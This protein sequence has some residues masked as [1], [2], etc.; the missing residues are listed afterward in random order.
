MAQHVW[1][2]CPVAS[3]AKL[4]RLGTFGAGGFDLSMGSLV[5][6]GTLLWCELILCWT[7]WDHLC[8]PPDFF[9]QSWSKSYWRIVFF[10][11]CPVALSSLPPFSLPCCLDAWWAAISYQLQ[12][13]I[14]RIWM[15]MYSC[16][17]NDCLNLVMWARNFHRR[18]S[19][20]PRLITR[21]YSKTY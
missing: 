3:A 13:H 1:Q 21:Q 14:H 18:F 5:T 2:I 8:S 6:G 11:Q 15:N 20:Q 17:Y 10:A 12:E 9:A 7:K 19:S 16:Q 4:P